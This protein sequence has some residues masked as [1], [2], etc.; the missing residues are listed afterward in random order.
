MVC[1]R[2]AQT[3]KHK[4]SAMGTA[5]LD[6]STDRLMRQLMDI[7]VNKQVDCRE[8]DK[9]ADRQITDGQTRQ[10]H[11]QTKRVTHCEY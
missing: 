10:T 8:T 2:H 7:V 6:Q 9:Q 4:D 11:K 1:C 3:Q 5:Q